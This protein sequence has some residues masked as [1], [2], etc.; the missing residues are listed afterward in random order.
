ML[1][2]N[3]GRALVRRERTVLAYDADHATELPLVASVESFAGLLVA[4]PFVAVGGTLLDASSGSA[5]GAL[6]GRPLLLT[7]SGDA[8][9]AE[10]G[11]AS[12][13]AFARGPL[14]FHRAA[15]PK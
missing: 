3:G 12:G 2:T 15:P 10:G 1:A 11:P 13:D 5:V 6:P 7:S 14:R 9:I 4:G 8:L